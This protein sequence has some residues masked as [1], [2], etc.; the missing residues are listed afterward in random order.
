MKRIIILVV[1][2]LVLVAP[3]PVLAGFDNAQ[4]T[5]ITHSISYT[6]RSS[7]VDANTQL[8]LAPDLSVALNANSTS[9]DQY[10]DQQ[11]A[12]DYIGLQDLWLLSIG[13][14]DI[15]VAVLD[16]GID[17]GHQDLEDKVISEIN[18][19]FS[20]TAGDVYGHGT[21]IAGIIA[22]NN[23]NIGI[24]GVAP[25]VKLLNVKVA[26]DRGRCQ[27]QNLVAGIIWA[28]DMGADVINIS[29]QIKES[30]PDLQKAI[31][32]AW[33][34][35]VI[36]V[37]AAGNNVTQ[38]Q[39]FPA[40]YDSVIAVAASDN[41][42]DLAP[43]SNYG[44][45]IDLAAPGHNVFSLLPGNKY[46]YETGTSFAAGYVSG[47]AALLVGLV[48]DQNN[49]GTNNDEIASVLR[50]GYTETG[51]NRINGVVDAE[52]ILNQVNGIS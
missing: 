8:N 1:L 36:V 45:W 31:D 52:S 4:T 32:Y 28:V 35:G 15:V 33:N 5:N 50:S 25:E 14:P 37:A 42:G 29:I 19:T 43:L 38:S 24:I 10:S 13:S 20:N 27:V 2:S 6:D 17:K 22:A 11:W 26:D 48:G 41:N 51:D 40:A 21:H 9:V 23:N 44:E 39:V 49:S 3:F 47:I 16:T 34:N 18:F 30:S 46:G 12:T 7:I